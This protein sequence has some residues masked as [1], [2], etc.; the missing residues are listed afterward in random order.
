MFGTDIEIIRAISILK[1]KGVIPKSF[2]RTTEILVPT[3]KET[4]TNEK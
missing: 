1:D 4:K 2:D 3:K